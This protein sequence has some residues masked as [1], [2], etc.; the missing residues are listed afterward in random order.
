MRFCLVHYDFNDTPAEV[1]GN[2]LFGINPVVFLAVLVVFGRLGVAYPERAEFLDEIAKFGIDGFVD[3]A[4]KVDTHFRTVVASQNGAVVYERNP[5]SVAG[6]SYG[7]T[8]TGNS[9]AYNDKVV[10]MRMS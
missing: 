9:A 10:I 8:H 6:S 3:V 5:Q 4:S 1:G 7:C 2:V